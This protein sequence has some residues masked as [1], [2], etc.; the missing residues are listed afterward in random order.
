ME[1]RFVQLANSQLSDEEFFEEVFISYIEYLYKNPKQNTFVQDL[2]RIRDGF[3]RND[4]HTQRHLRDK[5]EAVMYRYNNFRRETSNAYMIEIDR[6]IERLE[7]Q[8]EELTA[9]LRG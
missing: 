5:I 3:N 7:Q 1:S 6:N 2:T 4:P 9:R 8:L